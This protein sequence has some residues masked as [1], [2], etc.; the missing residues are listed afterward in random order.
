M[1]GHKQGITAAAYVPEDRPDTSP[2][3]PRMVDAIAKVP[4]VTDFR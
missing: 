3:W 4:V 2:Y 1:V